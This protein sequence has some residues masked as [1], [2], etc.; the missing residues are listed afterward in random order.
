VVEDKRPDLPNA[1]LID[2]RYLMRFERRTIADVLALGDGREH[3]KAFRV[4][5]RASEIGQ[6][7]YDSVVSPIVRG[8]VNEGVAKA[9]RAA[10]SDRLQRSLM[11]DQN[12][13]MLAVKAAAEKVRAE[14]KPVSRDNPFLAAEKRMSS[15][16]I[17]ALDAY[18]DSRDGMMER[19]FKAI[20]GSP[21]AA[22]AVGL[23]A[24][25]CRLPARRARSRRCSRRSRACAGSRRQTRSA[26]GT[27]L[28]GVMRTLLYVGREAH[29]IDER[30]SE[31]IRR[32]IR[33]LPRNNARASCS[34]ARRCGGSSRRFV[35]TRMRPSPRFRICF[36]PT[37]LRRKVI[38]AAHRI[39][40]GDARRTDPGAG[41]APRARREGPRRRSGGRVRRRACL[42]DAPHK[43][44]KYERLIAVAKALTAVADRRSR[45][46]CD[47]R[48]R[49][50]ARSTPPGWG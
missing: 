49:S 46:P 15:A 47:K 5:R 41:R 27:P 31:V 37:D 7:I 10:H 6:G 1:D 17:D 43:R 38:A 9:L 3:E 4:V 8:V 30:P 45:I 16:I 35:P 42:Q 39:G 34:C 18:R 22:A 40:L 21:F 32:I 50:R 44:E 11:L 13:A 48:A 25:P 23:R 29:A 19:T 33:D 36:P 28:D 12:P 20:W 2:G 14:R 24:G 26:K